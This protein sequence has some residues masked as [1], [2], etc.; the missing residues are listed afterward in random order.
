MYVS[1]LV[2]A[3]LTNELRKLLRTILLFVYLYKA[4]IQDGFA[5]QGC[6]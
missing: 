6:K 5:V 3:V 1:L 2:I 4:N